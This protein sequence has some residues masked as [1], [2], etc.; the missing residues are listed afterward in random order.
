MGSFHAFPEGSTLL[1]LILHPHLYPESPSYTRHPTC[2]RAVQKTHIYTHSKSASFK[3]IF[4]G[5]W[6]MSFD[7][8]RNENTDW[9][10]TPE[11]M[12]N[13]CTCASVSMCI[14]DRCMA[15]SRLS[16][17][18]SLSLWDE[19][20]LIIVWSVSVSTSEMWLSNLIK[21]DSKKR[22]WNNLQDLEQKPFVL[23]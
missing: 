21:N 16:F 18:L 12:L 5:T 14:L 19:R 22:M 23:R 2:T 8:Q 20:L 7:V 3:V 11:S 13:V 1:C 10:H 17:Y 6:N 4:K 15:V 9:P